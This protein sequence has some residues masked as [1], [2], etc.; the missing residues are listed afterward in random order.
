M[1][2][3]AICCDGTWKTPDG[4]EDGQSTATNVAKI[5]ELISPAGPDGTVQ[6]TYYH[7]GVGSGNPGDKFLGG[8]MGVGLSRIIEEAYR[9]L[10]SNY[11]SGDEIWLFGF[12]RGAY[13]ARSIIGLIRNSGLLK[14]QH[15]EKYNLAYQLYRDRSRETGPS[16][17]LADQFKSQFSYTPDIHF[18]GVWD[19]VGSL[20]VPD[21]IISKFLGGMW[22]FHDV[23]LSAIVQNA[24]HAL[25]IDEHR[26][27]FKPCAWVNRDDKSWEQVW[28]AG[29]HSDVGGGY[30]EAGL[31]DCALNWMMCKAESCGLKLDRVNVA[32]KPDPVAD[33]HDSKTGPYILR[34]THLRPIDA[35]LMSRAALEKHA[36]SGY[37]P[38]NWPQTPDTH[39]LRRQL[40]KTPVGT[41]LVIAGARG[42]SE[43]LP[44]SG[45]VLIR[46][47]VYPGED[48]GLSHAAVVL[49]LRYPPHQQLANDGIGNHSDTAL[50][51]FAFPGEPFLS[52]PGSS[53]LRRRLLQF[54]QNQPIDHLDAAGRLFGQPGGRAPGGLK[55]EDW[56]PGID[57]TIHARFVKDSFHAA[58]ANHGYRRR[59]LEHGP[60]HRFK[61][62][63]ALGF[64]AHFGI[65]SLSV[66]GPDPMDG[67]KSLP[68]Q[69]H[70]FIGK[71]L[72]VCFRLID[73]NQRFP[74]FPY[75]ISTPVTLPP[76]GRPRGSI[77]PGDQ[78]DEQRY[79]RMPS[80]D[81]PALF[82]QNGT[83]K[84]HHRFFDLHLGI[85]D[86]AKLDIPG[87]TGN[88]GGKKDR[89]P[90]QPLFPLR[91]PL[92]HSAPSLIPFATS[93]ISLS[94]KHA[95]PLTLP[96]Q[97]TR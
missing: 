14:K 90:A 28:F 84:A 51:I 16:G 34:P 52:F 37:T 85:G 79:G 26:G 31:S 91:P 58:D 40:F 2:R 30:T 11:V 25:A 35:N 48:G 92:A 70:R 88:T 8:T 45:F 33:I 44:R 76:F 68:E 39:A 9:F 93:A 19:T 71:V 24:Y 86:L 7:E 97:S 23:S 38:A 41:V 49:Q 78:P 80:K 89:L 36:K 6:V 21:H 47:F 1:K 17:N 69:L 60:T 82:R 65:E 29:A 4:E 57:F 55:R 67:C 20:G 81:K 75:L 27:D 43:A 61:G 18:L 22:N 10:A 32:V 42:S 12:S 96:S 56:R 62:P 72:T 59:L 74:P 64:I 83:R 5:A 53:P 77:F 46:A 94:S 87:R 54:F 63:G 15:L 3:I 73:L 13:T 95:T 66:D 50:R